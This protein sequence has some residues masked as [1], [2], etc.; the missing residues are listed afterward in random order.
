MACSARK[1]PDAGHL[2]AEERYDGSAWR[3]L[4]AGLRGIK[5][6]GGVPPTIV[7]LSA[8]FG[9]IAPGLPIPDYDRVMDLSRATEF[10]VDP[11]QRHALATLMGQVNEVFLGGGSLYRQVSRTALADNGFQGRLVE[12]VRPRGVGDLLSELRRILASQ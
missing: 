4:R 7:V 9:F 8:E 10:G 12:P 1:R 11:R 5:D 2:P 6:R 3:V